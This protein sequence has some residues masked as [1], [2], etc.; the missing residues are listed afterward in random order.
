[1]NYFAIDLGTYQVR[2]AHEQLSFNEPIRVS[3]QILAWLYHND[4]QWRIGEVVKEYLQQQNIEIYYDFFRDIQPES[5]LIEQAKQSVSAHD[6]SRILLREIVQREPNLNLAKCIVAVVPNYLNEQQRAQLKQIATSQQIMITELLDATYAKAYALVQQSYFDLGYIFAVYEWGAS[7]FEFAIFKVI[8]NQENLRDIQLLA[9]QHLAIG[10]YQCDQKIWSYIAQQ[11]QDQRQK[12]LTHAILSILDAQIQATKIALNAE[13]ER[14]ICIS[15]RFVFPISQQIFLQQIKI[16][17]EKIKTALQQ[18]LLQANLLKHQITKIYLTGG[19]SQL[20]MVKPM[21]HEY[22]KEA[23]LVEAYSSDLAVKGAVLYAQRINIPQH[24]ESVPEIL[25]TEIK[26][27]QTNPL[28]LDFNRPISAQNRATQV[29]PKQNIEV[30]LPPQREK[31][32]YSILWL[33]VTVILLCL[34]GMM[35]FNI[36]QQRHETPILFAE[37]CHDSAAN[38]VILIDQNSFSSAQQNADVIQQAWTALQDKSQSGDLISIYALAAQGTI[39]PVMQLCQFQQTQAFKTTFE[40]GIQQALVQTKLV[41][42]PIAESII[43][44]SSQL[45]LRQAPYRTWLIFSNLMQQSDALSIQQCTQAER[46]LSQFK[47]SRKGQRQRPLLNNSSIWLYLAKTTL[48][49]QQ[50]RCKNQFWLWF[51]NS[52][53]GDSSIHQRILE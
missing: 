3:Q 1:M 34:G 7:Q 5:T 9:R 43:E 10:G 50:T 53:E 26:P 39:Q 6:L 25:N 23:K 13:E 31:K 46:G 18:T 15:Q 32:T 37:Q 51:F 42:Q 29:I 30:T 49:E 27:I 2:V 22:F 52:M 4:E 40:Q 20:Y 38:I 19:S 47:Q 16:D 36:H 45:D 28:S 35:Y 24:T 33:I 48:D 17:L 12:P 8:K 11:Y 44:I 41:M 21:L 14:A